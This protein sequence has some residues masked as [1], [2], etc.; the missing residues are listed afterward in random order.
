MT[1]NKLT[2]H[3]TDAFFRNVKDEYDFMAQA[4]KMMEKF[5]LDLDMKDK[6]KEVLR[7]AINFGYNLAIEEMKEKK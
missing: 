1:K 6:L 7:E 5:D 4:G 2:T 3:Q